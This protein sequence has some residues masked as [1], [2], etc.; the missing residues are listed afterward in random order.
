M[1]TGRCWFR[2]RQSVIA[3][4]IVKP[5]TTGASHAKGTRVENPTAERTTITAAYTTAGDHHAA[6]TRVIGASTA[7]RAY[8]TSSGKVH[9]PRRL[10]VCSVVAEA[11]ARPA[12]LALIS[13]AA[14]DIDSA[15]PP[16]SRTSAGRLDRG[17][18]IGTPRAVPTPDPASP[19]NA[20]SYAP[21]T[22]VLLS[23]GCGAAQFPVESV[24]IGQVGRPARRV[25]IV[26]SRMTSK[27]LRLLTL[28]VL[29]VAAMP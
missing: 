22:P 18:T 12:S 27:L 20:S 6:W 13:A 2:P 9:K 11:G 28:A 3:A 23:Y 25:L 26:L 16:R 8:S 19:R 15:A 10:M 4:A 29:C 21:I 24:R 14:I 7:Y 5:H 17:H 1:T